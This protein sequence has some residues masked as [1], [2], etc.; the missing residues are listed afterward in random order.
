MTSVSEPSRNQTV[1]LRE[2]NIWTDGLR[3]SRFDLGIL[4]EEGAFTVTS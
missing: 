1:P 2:M 3:A 4:V